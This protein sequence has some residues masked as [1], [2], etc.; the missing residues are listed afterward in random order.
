MHGKNKKQ[1]TYARKFIANKSSLHSQSLDLL[2]RG[3]KCILFYELLA[4][5]T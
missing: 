5:F 4:F 2:F 1:K 3:N